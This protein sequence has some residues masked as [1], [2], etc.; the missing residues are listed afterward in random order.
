MARQY[1]APPIAEVLCEF[2]FSPGQ[3]WDWTI[4]GLLYDKVKGDFPKKSQQNVLQVELRAEREEIT[5]NIKGGMARMQFLRADEHALMQVGPDLLVINH[6][7]PYSGWANFKVDI[8]RCLATYC[9]IV[10]PQGIQRIGLRYI[11]KIEF[12]YSSVEIDDYLLTAPRIPNEIPQVF[13]SWAQRVEVPYDRLGGSLVLQTGS[14]KES[15][16][17]NTVFL[18]DLNFQSH[19]EELFDTDTAL[20]WVEQAHDNLEAAFEASITPKARVFF[21]EVIRDDSGDRD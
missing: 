19:G 10:Q 16:D 3:P 17:A 2:Y 18:L 4:P 21:K 7:R 13:S 6:L 20:E 15:Q 12:P 8:K 1:D 14:L 11:N 9:D 5:Q